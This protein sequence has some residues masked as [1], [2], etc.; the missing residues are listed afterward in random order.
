VVP[1]ISKK[2]SVDGRRLRE[3]W[4]QIVMIDNGVILE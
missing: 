1:F 3:I 2:C 4:A